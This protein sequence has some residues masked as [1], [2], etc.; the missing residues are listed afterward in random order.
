MPDG[1]RIRNRL[2]PLATFALPLALILGLAAQARPQGF[3]PDA[4]PSRM[5]MADGLSVSLYAA[6]PDVRQPILAKFDDRGR[7]WCI[8]YLQYPN[9]AGLERIKVDRYS[10]TVYDRVPDPPPKG[11]RGD[12][13][14]TICEDTDGDGRADRFKDFATGLNLCTGLA[15]GHGGV[16]VLQVPYLLFYPDRDRDDSPD[17]DPEVL[18]S[19]FGMEDAQSLVNHLTW[20]PDGW[21]Y[22]VT[23]S[24]VSN[25]ISGL[26]F[27]QAVWR[28]EPRSKRFELFCEGGGNLFGLTFDADGNLFF[29]SNGNDL[30]YHA[31]QGA[32]YRKNFGKHGPL[33]NP[34]TYGFF[35]HLTFDGEVA[36]PRPGG[37][38]YRGDSLPDRFRGAFLCC[39]FLQ[40]SASWWR[41][42]SRGSTFSATYGGRLLDARDSWFCAP[43]LA[44]GPDGAVY[45]CDFH[46]RRTA[47]PDPDANWDRS[48]G[49][50]YRIAPPGSK[51]TR[52]LDLARESGP[53]LV[54]LLRHPNGWLADRAR[55]QLATRRDPD[56]R[57][58]LAAMARQVADPRLA[59][60]GLWG[61]YVGG[62]LDDSLAADLLQ[63]PSEYVRAWTIRLLGDAPEVAPRLAGRFAEM[64]RSDPSVVVRCQLAATS[65]RLPGAEGLPIVEALLLRGLDRDDPYLPLMLWWA[66][67]ARALTDADRLL[68]FFTHP[69]AWDDPGRRE[70][71]LRLVR[72]YAAEG[73]RAGY[74]ASERLLQSVPEGL[75]PEALAALDRGLAERSVSTGGMGMAGLFGPVAV[76]EKEKPALARRFEPI[77]ESLARAIEV[78][79]RDDPAD[80]L[81]LR[82]AI[83]AEVAGARASVL[84]GAAT[85]ATPPA[86]RRELLGLLADL[87]DSR[88]APVALAILEG[89]NPPDV[90][91]EALEV[92]ARHGDDRS[93]ARLLECYPNRTEA[94][95]TKIREVLLSRP[96]SAR[97]LLD[98]VDRGEIAAEDIPVEQLR[99]VALHGDPG[100]DALVRK[101]WG[102]VRAGTPEEKLAEMRRLSND[103]RDGLGDRARGE[104]SFGR[105]CAACHKLFGKGG[106]VGPD[107]TGVAR[108]DTTALLANIVDPGAVIRAT[109]LQY[110]A[111]LRD[112]RVVSGVLA[113]RDDAS[114]T[115]VDAQGKRTRLPLDDIE[116]VREL[117]T[118]IMPED[119]LKPLDSQEI[120]DLFRYLQGKPGD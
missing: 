64:A 106:E 116:E 54:E 8:Q 27:Q 114:L 29:S 11:P 63:H 60:Q 95:R 24:T 17:G 50:I 73:T 65:R 7:L 43:D 56:T 107:L 120:R 44:Q 78:A 47:H 102:A 3:A 15:F 16:Y 71:A 105:R 41:L 96:G 100:L 67:E 34:H 72:R 21:L 9:P 42:S 55:D 28:F 10:R 26:E 111:A 23:G 40:H 77:A 45:V 89:N 58:A 53:G 104:A 88:A 20:G 38:I 118:S 12:D 22:G 35:E 66:L 92:L 93:A 112:G 39:D 110:A 99:R 117:P 97:S 115:L 94:L 1:P 57:P 61:S 59:L 90:Q 30:A 32:Y 52:G 62:G 49:R 18:L 87:G 74:D 75:R 83:R 37:T 85:P 13:R 103:L 108:E 2:G 36:G 98:R 6:E 86:R 109:Y 4:A 31:V 76:P 33:H 113:A 48:N 70:N 69:K 19:G 82:L 5:A 68:S 46:D 91:I 101:H 14:I 119:L 51:P 84:E 79:W 80:L 25:R 81:R